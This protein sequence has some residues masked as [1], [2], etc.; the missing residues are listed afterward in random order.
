MV[1]PDVYARRVPQRIRVQGCSGAGKTTFARAL[2][3]RLDLPH[4]ELDAVNHREG[5][6]EA[7]DAEWDRSVED[8]LAVAPDGWVACGNYSRRSARLSAE[9]DTVVWLDYSRPRVMAQVLRRTLGRLV[10]RRELWNGNRE[11]WGNLLRHEP[12]QNIVLWAW[13]AYPGHVRRFRPQWEAGRAP[14]SRPR[15]V[16]LSGP[17]AARAWLERVTKETWPT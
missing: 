7:T 10:T 13:T 1:G 4:L 17:A 12:E 11:H 15:W 8:F 2:A 3:E 9:A 14:G 16:R 6:R 5:W